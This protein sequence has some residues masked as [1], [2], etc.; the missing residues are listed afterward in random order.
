HVV[1]MNSAPAS[2]ARAGKGTSGGRWA[3]PEVCCHIGVTPTGT[4][5]TE[6]VDVLIG[7]QIIDPAHSVAVNEAGHGTAGGGQCV[8]C[9]GGKVLILP[10]ARA[11]PEQV[12]NML[13]GAEIKCV[14]RTIR[15]SKTRQRTS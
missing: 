9:D 6:L 4:T 15:R 10:A 2:R 8:A 12:P 3:D 7:V 13:V 1:D 5:A 14:R 11:I